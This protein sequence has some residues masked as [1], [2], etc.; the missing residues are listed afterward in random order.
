MLQGYEVLRKPIRPPG[1]LG[2][3]REVERIPSAEN[4][5]EDEKDPNQAAVT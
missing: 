1:L 3:E 2:L 5:I 4:F